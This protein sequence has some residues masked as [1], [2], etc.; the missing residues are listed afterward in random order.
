MRKLLLTGAAALGL[1][2]AAANAQAAYVGTT[3]AAPDPFPN[4]VIPGHEGWY[5]ANVYLIAGSNASATI[6]F[7]GKEAGY[8]NEFYLNGTLIFNNLVAPGTSVNVSLA[9]GLIPFMFAV[10]NTGGTVTNGSNID[11]SVGT[12]NFWITLYT[13]PSG[14]DTT[15]DGI[16]PGSGTVALL[17]L[18]DGGAGPDDNHDDMVIRITLTNATIGVPEPASLG[19][20]GAG[21]VGMGL[22][23]RRRRKA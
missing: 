8:T 4:D 16:T 18:D 15:I 7:I 13:P 20:L 14:P 23:A 6:E 21:L 22:V 19:L 3:P 12:P 17:A 9:P 5:G 11:P 10:T 1:T 2:L